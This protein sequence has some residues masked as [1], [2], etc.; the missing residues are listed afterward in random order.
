LIVKDAAPET[1]LVTSSVAV[2]VTNVEVIGNT[3]PELWSHAIVYGLP[4]LPAVAV[5]VKTAAAPAA[6]VASSV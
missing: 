4:G 6:D 5:T 2:Q 3:S 1:S